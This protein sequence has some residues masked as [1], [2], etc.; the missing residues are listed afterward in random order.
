V[1]RSETLRAGLRELL[2]GGELLTIRELSQS[3]GASERDLYE[4]LE[5]LARSLPHTGERLNI[6][7]SRCL[8]CGF[9]FGER[10]RFKKP[11]R[12]PECKS[13]RISTPR[14]GIASE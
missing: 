3:L 9:E 10:T 4:H 8:A 7:P 13:T 1:E 14:F 2:R 5:H 12:C 6:E 11:G